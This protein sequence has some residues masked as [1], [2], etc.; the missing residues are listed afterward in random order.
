MLPLASI[1]TMSRRSTELETPAPPAES[2]SGV[3]SS[4]LAAIPLF[5]GCCPPNAI[6]SLR[7]SPAGRSGACG[8]KM[9]GMRGLLLRKTATLV[10]AYSIALQ[11][12][13]VGFAVGAHAGFSSF[14][15]ICESNS[16]GDHNTPPQKGR[17]DCSACPLA[18]GDG[19][20][21]VVPLDAKL[22]LVLFANEV[23]LS[24]L[25]FEA[26]PSPPKHQLQASRAPPI[27]G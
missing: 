7:R 1:I 11:G 8:A 25:R 12:L 2:R 5:V 14:V 6:P 10:V 15:V 24:A 27:V 19:S 3:K 17:R 23:R 20:S 13:L 18:C 26:L 21:G 4:S 22:S 9:P 16:T